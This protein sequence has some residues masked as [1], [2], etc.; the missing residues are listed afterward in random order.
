VERHETALLTPAP[1]PFNPQTVIRFS[2]ARDGMVD[3]AVYDLQG[4]RVRTVA[5][6]S[7]AAGSHEAIWLGD[8]GQGRR[9]PS[10]VYFARLEADGQTLTRRIALV[11]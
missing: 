5:S 4:R 8:D 10:G 2:L 11:K 6:G 1:N 3:L 7:Y 9:L